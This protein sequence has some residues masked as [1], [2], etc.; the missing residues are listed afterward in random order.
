[1]LLSGLAIDVRRV[2][3]V[4]LSYESDPTV[5]AGALVSPAIGITG[6][7]VMTCRSCSGFGPLCSTLEAAT[8]SAVSL[9]ASRI[10]LSLIA[11]IFAFCIKSSNCDLLLLIHVVFCRSTCAEWSLA[12]T[13]VR[14]HAARSLRSCE[15]VRLALV[16][17]RLAF[18]MLIH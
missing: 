18:Q 14:S 10:F 1:M 11:P 4:F 7:E 12:D 9:D 17:S 15:G 3:C 5:S 8:D 16:E 13:F 2:V 6:L